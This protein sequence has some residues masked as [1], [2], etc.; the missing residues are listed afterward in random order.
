MKDKVYAGHCSLQGGGVEHAGVHKI[1]NAA[2]E[3]SAI[4]GAK[5]VEYSHAYAVLQSPRDM[6]PDKAGTASDQN[7][8]RSSVGSLFA[9]NRI[10]RRNLVD[11]I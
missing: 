5:I 7:S 11:R 4:S 3:S 8:H 10:P 9:G 1:D 2:F 6:A